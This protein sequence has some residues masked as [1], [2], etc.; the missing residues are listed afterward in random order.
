M[1]SG[2]SD[3]FTDDMYDVIP[4]EKSVK[5]EPI[6]V[7]KFG[8]EKETEQ[9]VEKIRDILVKAELAGYAQGENSRLS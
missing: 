2:S 9:I 4:L 8:Y 7:S 6:K 5:K 3:L 1:T